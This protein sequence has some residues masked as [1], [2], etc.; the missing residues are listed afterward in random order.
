M[1]IATIGAPAQ[2]RLGAR[3]RLRD[4]EQAGDHALNIAVHDRC[5][6][7]EG[8]GR[9]GGGGV[10]TDAGEP[11]QR[12][13]AVGKDAAV[14]GAHDA[15]AFVQVARPRVVAEA[16]PGVE[17]GIEIGG[18]ELPHGR[19]ARQEVA[20]VGA[21]GHD[22]GLLQHDL[23]EPHAI[24]IGAL[25]RPGTPGQGAGVAVV[26]GK[27]RAGEIRRR[28]ARG[29][30]AAGH[31]GGYHSGAGPTRPISREPSWR[32]RATTAPTRC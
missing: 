25:A 15:R 7:T 9:D 1:A 4:P 5:P 19:P 21:D 3:Q 6:A 22:R 20:E 10:G 12:L 8:D 18:G 31:G 29:G 30:V 17:D 28:A 13:L 2:L 27:Q 23:A 11:A 26:P 16:L 32:T 14:L 24:G